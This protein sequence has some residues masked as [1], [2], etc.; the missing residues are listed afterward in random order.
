MFHAG[1]QKDEQT[2]YSDCQP[3][4]LLP[5]CCPFALTTH[6]GESLSDL[7]SEPVR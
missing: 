5:V 3:V 7:G 4:C 6:L 2:W 1:K